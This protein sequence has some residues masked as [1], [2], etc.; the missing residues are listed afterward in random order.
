MHTC[1]SCV[2][3]LIKTSG[4]LF[5]GTQPRDL[6]LCSGFTPGKSCRLVKINGLLAYNS[7][8]CLSNVLPWLLGRDK[9]MLYTILLLLLFIASIIKPSANSAC[10]QKSQNKQCF[11]IEITRYCNLMCVIFDFTHFMSRSFHS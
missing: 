9:V 5:G 3:K 7:L 2:Y 10:V 6:L 8:P 1:N 11:N 4:L